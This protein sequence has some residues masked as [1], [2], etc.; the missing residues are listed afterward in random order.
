[1]ELSVDYTDVYEKIKPY[2]EW[3]GNFYAQ[4]INQPDLAAN[5]TQEYFAAYYNPDIISNAIRQDGTIVLRFASFIAKRRLIDYIR[6]KCISTRYNL[7]PALVYTSEVEFFNDLQQPS[8]IL[9]NLIL[10]EDIDYM[11]SLIS[12]L[13]GKQQ[14]AIQLVYI[15]GITQRQAS[16]EMGVT[17]SRISQL[18]KVARVQLKRMITI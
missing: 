18:L 13:K 2:A 17:E 7:E 3:F 10:D 4:K 11:Q 1:M 5:F 9:G 12:K 16:I 15:K 14:R 8:H 6:S